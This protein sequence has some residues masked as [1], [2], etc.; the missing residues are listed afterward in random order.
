M[1]AGYLLDKTGSF[2]TVFIYFGICAA[3]GLIMIMLLEEPK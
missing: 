3:I 2:N 1:L